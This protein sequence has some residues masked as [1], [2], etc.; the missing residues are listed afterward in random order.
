MPRPGEPPLGAGESSSVPGTAAIANAIFDATGVRFR[1]PPFT[2]EVV[3]AALHPLPAPPAPKAAVA[4]ACARRRASADRGARPP[5]R[6]RRAGARDRTPPCRHAA[7]ASR[8]AAVRCWRAARRSSPALLGWRPAIAPVAQSS[9]SDAR[10]TAPPPSSAAACWPRSA[11]ARSATPRRAARANA[12]GRAMET[13]FGTVYSTNLTPDA[14]TGLGRWSFSAFQRAMREGVSRDGHHLYPAF[15]YTA[16]AKTS[17]DDLQ[18][19]YAYLMAQPRGAR[20]HAAGRDEVPVQPAAAHGRLERA[21][22][23]PGAAASRS[24]RRAPNGTAAPTWSTAW[25][26]AAPATRRAMRWAPSRAAAPSCPAPWSTAGKRRRSRRCRSAAVP[27]NADA[28]YRYLRHGHAPQHGIA[29]RADGRGGARTGDGARCRHPRHGD[30]PR[31]LQPGRSTDADGGAPQAQQAVA[32]P[33]PARAG[34]S[35]LRSACSTAPARPATTTATARRC[36]ASTRRWRSTASS[37]ASG[38]TTCCAP[39]STACA[40]RRRRDIGFMPAFRDA[41]DDA[42]I[43]RTGRLHAR[44]LRAP[45]PAWKDL[46]GQVARV[47][48]GMPGLAGR[49]AAGRCRRTQKSRGLQT[50]ALQAQAAIEFISNQIFSNWKPSTMPL[51]LTPAASLPRDA[52]RATLIGRL[53]QPGIGPTLVARAP[54]RP[55]RPVALAPTTSQLL[56]LGRPAGAVRHA[57]AGRHRAARRRARRGAGQQRRSACAMPTQPWLL[58]PCDL[59]AVKASGVTFVASLLERVIEEQARGDASSAPRRS[60]RRARRRAGRQPGRHRARL[61]RGGARSRRC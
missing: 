3:R 8:G 35:A 2:P 54:G 34:C 30:L 13:P 11:T 10:S 51:N 57:L 25:A 29:G 1:A 16:F 14:D 26:T 55:A 40:S 12:G 20:R 53:W 18:A 45:A 36:W 38:P 61:A 24:P 48:N 28:L 37:P 21:V 44:A 9:A 6:L 56:E 23:R 4:S 22:P 50:R 7:A 5:R 42:Q 32:A 17:D 47:R 43:A 33:R 49:R 27:W 15:P 46:P 31:V 52:E 59:Q 39:S 41:L 19:L 60:A 58:A